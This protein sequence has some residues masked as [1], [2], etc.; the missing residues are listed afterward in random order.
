MQ[1]STCDFFL[2]VLPYAVDIGTQGLKA[3]IR[4]VKGTLMFFI[5]E[6]GPDGKM[7]SKPVWQNDALADDDLS[8][9][10]VLSAARAG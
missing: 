4:M 10:D 9:A 8:D 1:T 7:H 6:G 5:D 2:P 3:Y